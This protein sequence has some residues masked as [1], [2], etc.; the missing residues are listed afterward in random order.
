MG[1]GKGGRKGLP[2]PEPSERSHARKPEVPEAAARPEPDSRDAGAVGAAVGGAAALLR[3]GA[4]V[5]LARLSA[6]I[7]HEKN[8]THTYRGG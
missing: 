6:T 1:G 8:A 4:H 7:L 3:A 2:E 5:A